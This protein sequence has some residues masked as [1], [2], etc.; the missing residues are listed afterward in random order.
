MGP[1]DPAVWPLKEESFAEKGECVAFDERMPM[2][3]SAM[4]LGQAVTLEVR[5]NPKNSSYCFF[6][7]LSA[8][9]SFCHID[10]LQYRPICRNVT[11]FFFVR[12]MYFFR[13]VPIRFK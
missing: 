4:V 1:L 8:S 11:T 13:M 10:V 6:R 2:I 3:P 12:R 5:S 7:E 9:A